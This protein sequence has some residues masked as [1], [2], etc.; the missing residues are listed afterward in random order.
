MG[1]TQFEQKYSE[2]YDVIYQDKD[3]EKEC[4]FIERIFSKFGVRVSSVL[5]LGCGSGGHAIPLSQKGYSVTGVD[6]S[7]HMLNKAI[8][9]TN[10]LKASC[11]FI[12]GDIRKIQINETFDAVI[13][14]F[15]VISYQI[16][17][18]DFVS[19]FETAYKHLKKGGTFIFDFWFGPAVLSEKPSLKFKEVKLDKIRIIRITT[20][21][22]DIFSNTVDVNFK[23]FVIDENRKSFDFFEELHRV[24]Y[25]FP[26]EIVSSLKNVGFSE[27][28]FFP[29]LDLSR[30]PNESDWNVSCVA[31]K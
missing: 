13:S 6:I 29:F 7:A 26:R 12:Q 11:S 16:E 21:S 27:I 25:F 2:I 31:L 1:I 28:H 14:M 4:D 19:A 22:I 15:A 20:P 9:K 30:K 24:R 5:D 17:D 8:E 3:Y 23:V 10:K 18:Q